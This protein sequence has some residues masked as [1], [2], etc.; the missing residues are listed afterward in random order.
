MNLTPNDAGKLPDQHKTSPGHLL[1]TIS[2][3]TPDERRE[4]LAQF[5]LLPLNEPTTLAQKVEAQF[6]ERFFTLPTIER[7]QSEFMITR[8]Q[9][10]PYEVQEFDIYR[11]FKYFG[12][13][14]STY[15][16]A[17]EAPFSQSAVSEFEKLARRLVQWEASGDSDPFK[18]LNGAL[19]TTRVGGLIRH[20]KFVQDPAFLAVLEALHGLRR[21]TLFSYPTPYVHLEK[22][23]QAGFHVGHIETFC[24]VLQNEKLWQKEGILVK[25]KGYEA[26]SL[27]SQIA[28]FLKIMAKDYSKETL[29][30]R[31]ILIEKALETGTF[32]PS[33]KYLLVYSFRTEFE[34]HAL[35]Q[36]VSEKAETNFAKTLTDILEGRWNNVCWAI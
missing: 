24:R 11:L 7:V 2:M 19:L 1:E 10:S 9:G 36:I 23:P 32:G 20:P 3:L 4:L 33:L 8:D 29:L 14:I 16:S 31:L 34:K 18:D 21:A 17:T 27:S 13:Q 25:G 22:E 6:L 12:E 15:Y 30:P 35:R 5:A 28:Q 26:S